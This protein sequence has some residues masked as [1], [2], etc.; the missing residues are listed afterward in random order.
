MCVMHTDTALS[1]IL[2]DNIHTLDNSLP[3]LTNL[4][5]ESKILIQNVNLALQTVII[6]VLHSN[7]YVL[8]TL[9]KTSD[10]STGK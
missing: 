7:Y 3:T 1:C 6:Y 9:V 8:I 2:L 4:C 10:P 5:F